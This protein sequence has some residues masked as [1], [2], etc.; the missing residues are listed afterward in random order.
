MGSNRNEEDIIIFRILIT[1]LDCTLYVHVQYTIIFFSFFSPY[2][3][4]RDSR[5]R[6][7][8]IMNIDNTNDTGA[9]PKHFLLRVSRALTLG[10]TS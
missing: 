1:R 6:G 7:I 5:R 4:S 8:I 2:V 10:R 9:F 3:T